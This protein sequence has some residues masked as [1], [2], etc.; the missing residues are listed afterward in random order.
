M[1]AIDQPTQDRLQKA[2]AIARQ[3]GTL[4]AAYFFGSRSRGQGD[5]WSDLDLAF[6]IKDAESWTLRQRTLL[7]VEVQ[8]MAG[9]DIEPHFFSAKALHEPSKLGFESIVL[10]EGIRL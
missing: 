7:T 4:E 6:F 3:H 8:K 2:V 10:A 5:Q 1:P 9:D